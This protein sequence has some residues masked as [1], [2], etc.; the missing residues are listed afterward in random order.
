L[1]RYYVIDSFNADKP[2]DQFVREQL[3]G[4]ILARTGSGE[5][6]AEQVI[7]TTFLGLSRRYATAPYEFWHLSLEDTID[8]VG[9]AFLGLTLRCS[10]CHD[11]KYDPVTMQDYYGLYGIF[12]STQYPWGG[13]EEFSSKSTPRQHFVPTIPDADA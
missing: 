6:F 10:R 5:R 8:T 1:Y 2:Y 3:A 12:D 9:Q 13:G 7:A 4:D 11:H